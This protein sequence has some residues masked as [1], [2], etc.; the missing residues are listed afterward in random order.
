MNHEPHNTSPAG[1]DDTAGS[2]NT[3]ER[4]D[5]CPYCGGSFVHPLDWA[6]EGPCHWR[7]TLRCPDCE[8]VD[9]GIFPAA[10]VEH[11]DIELD[12]ATSELLEDL[13]RITNANM[14]E[15]AEFFIRALNADVI[16]PSDF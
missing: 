13:R 6:E 3:A 16:V 10:V 2:L 12:R 1:Q 11:L 7:V 8:Q 5:I 14:S 4:I 15:E 9:T